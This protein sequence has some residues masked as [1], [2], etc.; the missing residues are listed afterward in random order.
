MMK[1]SI[2][3]LA[4]F[5]AAALLGGQVAAA[6][7]IITNG[8]VKL[9]VD[10]FGQLNI[11]GGRLS[12][13]GSTTIVGLRFIDSR[14]T[15]WES[16]ADGC[17]CEGW[18]VGVVGGL[19][20]GVRGY[21]NNS[22]GIAG[23]TGVSFTSTA[24][25]AV[26]V[27]R[28]GTTFEITHDYHPSAVPNLYEVTVSI[29]NI[30]GVNVDGDV[31]YRRL[32]D[33]DI[34]PTAFSELVTLQGWPAATLIHSTDNGFCSADVLSPCF[35]RTA[36]HTDGNFTKSGP[37]DHG[38]QFDF[39]FGTLAAG[40]SHSFT[41]FFGAAATESELLAA[42]T[43]VGAEIYSMAFCSSDPRCPAAHAYGFKGVGGTVI[44]GAV[45]E[46][47]TMGLLALGLVSLGAAGVRRRNK[48]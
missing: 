42:L 30:S 9:G 35:E 18:G 14:G 40:E 5:L 25:G 16:T 10:E 28:I 15:E 1:R 33:W 20:D 47:A 44:G 43:A 8:T 19:F 39:S 6:Q 45:P 2:T 36:G 29:K 31:R 48:A 12:G 37:A 23:L 13:T 4:A 34:E 3:G 26:S 46:P 27:V 17:L 41:T 7:A 11:P 21:A 24:T 22:A 38:A 32:M